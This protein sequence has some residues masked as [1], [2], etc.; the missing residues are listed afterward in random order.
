MAT[1]RRFKENIGEETVSIGKGKDVVRAHTGPAILVDDAPSMDL[2]KLEI[3]EPV[4][5]V[6]Y[7][8]P[9]P[10]PTPVLPEEYQPKLVA[11]KIA[12]ERI[13]GEDETIMD[14][15]CLKLLE[16]IP[17]DASELIR[18]FQAGNGVPMWQV[19]GGY[20]MRAREQA[21][22]F[23]PIILPDWADSIAPN[24]ARPCGTCGDAM[25]TS[26]PGQQFCCNRCYHGKDDHNEDCAVIKEAA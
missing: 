4:A 19:I 20:V 22:L 13:K 24:A 12:L 9:E 26:V 21:E 11:A 14:A 17:I 6:K 1:G 15:G 18:E 7:E 23:S 3:P 5:P 8:L 16:Y 2:P 25:K 10:M